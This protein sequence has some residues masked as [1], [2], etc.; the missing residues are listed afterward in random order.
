MKGIYFLNAL[1]QGDVSETS[2]DTSEMAPF[3]GIIGS[4]FVFTETLNKF[5]FLGDDFLLAR[6]TVVL[7]RQFNASVILN[8]EI[9]R[10]EMIDGPL[11]FLY[12]DTEK[13]VNHSESIKIFVSDSD[14]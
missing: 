12:L 13:N 11:C 14:Y 3:G 9:I 2:S 5:S 8:P 4:I 7:L 6:G 1:H 10:A